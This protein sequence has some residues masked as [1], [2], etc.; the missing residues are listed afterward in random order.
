[1]CEENVGISLVSV[2]MQGQ[3]EMICA[4]TTI[5]KISIS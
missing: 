4:C 1:M 2:Q 3:G 5:K